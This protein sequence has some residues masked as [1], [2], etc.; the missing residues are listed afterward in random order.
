MGKWPSKMTSF[1]DLDKKNGKQGVSPSSIPETSQVFHLTSYIRTLRRCVL[2]LPA[3]KPA[4]LIVFCI[5]EIRTRISGSHEIKLSQ[6]YYDLICAVIIT[7]KVTI[8]EYLIK[9]QFSVLPLVRV[10][11]ENNFQPSTRNRRRHRRYCNF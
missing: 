9:Y 10:R 7:T 5:I 4:S 3:E 1:K 2:L 6:M 11:Q 8:L